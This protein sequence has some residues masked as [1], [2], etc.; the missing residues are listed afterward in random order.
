MLGLLNWRIRVL[1]VPS[2]VFN[3]VTVNPYWHWRDLSV[4]EQKQYTTPASF[5]AFLENQSMKCLFRKTYSRSDL[6]NILSP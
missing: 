6:N 1:R 2:E 3:K 5:G 4:E